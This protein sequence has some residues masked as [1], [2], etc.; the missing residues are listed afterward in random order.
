MTRNDRPAPQRRCHRQRERD[1]RWAAVVARDHRRGRHL[2]LL[3]RD[4]RRLLPAVVR[5]APGES[6]ERALP[7]DRW[8][9]GAAGFR[10]CRRCRP[11]QP[12]L[13]QLHAAKI[14]A[15]CRVIETA[16]E[17]ADARGAGGRAGLSPYHFH[18][19]FKAVT[20]VT[21]G[22]MARRRDAARDPQRTQEEEQDRDRGNLRCR[23]QFRRTVLRGVRRDCWG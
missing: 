21:P 6:E 13:E 15:I 2:F 12:P 16:G 23:I 19:V 8:R 5:V 11:D 20:G 1:P 3:G 10:P 22:R 9:R 18:R 4:D 7:S 17:D 14:A